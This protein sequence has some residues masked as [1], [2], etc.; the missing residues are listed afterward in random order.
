MI[1]YPPPGTPAAPPPLPPLPP[2]PPP[3]PP[4][5]K[6]P[7]SPGSLRTG[8]RNESSGKTMHDGLNHSKPRSEL[9]ERTPAPLVD[10]PLP[11][12]KSDRGAGGKASSTNGSLFCSQ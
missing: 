3:L 4:W 10:Q 7:S 12:R 9:P 2:L 1:V 11:F 5:K 6:E 8:S